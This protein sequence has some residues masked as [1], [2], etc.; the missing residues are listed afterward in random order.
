MLVHDTSLKITVLYFLPQRSWNRGSSWSRWASSTWP[1]AR[2]TGL[3]LCHFCPGPQKSSR[4]RRVCWIRSTT[5]VYMSDALNKWH[6]DAAPQRA[7]AC[8]QSSVTV[9]WRVKQRQV[10]PPEFQKVET[11]GGE[12]ILTNAHEGLSLTYPNIFMSKAPC[13][14]NSGLKRYPRPSVYAAYL[15][16]PRYGSH[17]S[18]RGQATG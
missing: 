12:T 2:G 17:L 11:V 14:R 5:N 16:Q 4:R 15:Q 9:K 18:V 7:I 8:G 1:A 6:G 3:M 10:K 13:S